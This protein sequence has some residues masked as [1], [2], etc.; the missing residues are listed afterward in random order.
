MGWMLGART[1]FAAGEGIFDISLEGVLT[2]PFLYLRTQNTRAGAT[3]YKDQIR[4]DFV[5][6]TPHM[7]GALFYEENFLGYRWGGD[8][9][10]GNL[11]AKY[12][13]Y[14]DGKTPWTLSANLMVM[15]HGVNDKWTIWTKYDNGVD[16]NDDEPRPQDTP[17]TYEP[18]QYRP[19]SYVWN[20][21]ALSKRTTAALTTALSVTGSWN[22]WEGFSAYGQADLVFVDNKGNIAGN[23]K[24]DIQYS[25]G[26]QW[27][28]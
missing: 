24:S 19:G 14:K 20:D 28:F 22:F 9:L 18:G 15:L 6:A 3:E 8:A 26:L 27:C 21:D 7:A 16:G 1:S 12:T 17:S 13:R 2:D 4:L 5:V 23:N 25:L 10:V 11:Q